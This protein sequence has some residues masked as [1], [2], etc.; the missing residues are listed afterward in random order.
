M[1][2]HFEISNQKKK[3]KKEKKSPILTFY[4]LIKLQ[5]AEHNFRIT[6]RFLPTQTI[7]DAIE[8]N[9][10]EVGNIDFKIEPNKA[11]NVVCFL[12]FLASFNC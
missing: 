10:L 1:R 8:Q 2:N 4:I 3:K 6:N 7:C 12:L 9:Q 11:E 5:Y